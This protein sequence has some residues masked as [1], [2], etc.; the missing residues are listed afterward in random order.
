VF[1][2]RADN[3]VFVGVNDWVKGVL[4]KKDDRGSLVDVSESGG[5]EN[6]PPGVLRGC[7][8]VWE[9]G[10]GVSFMGRPYTGG[11]DVK[12]SCVVVRDHKLDLLALFRL[13]LSVKGPV[14]L[15]GNEG[16]RMS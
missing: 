11:G 10:K 1:V 4:G 7:P 9:L 16:D 6:R 14:V 13:V 8:G 3:M 5:G 15:V 12:L 2:L